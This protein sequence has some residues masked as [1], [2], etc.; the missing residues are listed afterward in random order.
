MEVLDVSFT[1]DSSV[2][3]VS[4]RELGPRLLIASESGIASIFLSS[5]RCRRAEVLKKR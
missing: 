2:R 5:L 4:T 3:A 1:R